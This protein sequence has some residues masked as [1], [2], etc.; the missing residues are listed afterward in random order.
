M[1][2]DLS[3]PE[4]KEFRLELL[5]LRMGVSEDDPTL[6]TIK[7]AAIRE[8]SIR[9]NLFAEL[10]REPATEGQRERFIFRL[11]MY[12]LVAKE[13]YLTMVGCN[14]TRAGKPLFKFKKGPEG[15]FL[16]MN[17]NQ[18]MAAWGLI[19]DETA[20]EIH[21]KVLELNPHWDI[22]S[23]TAEEVGLGE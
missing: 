11:P 13:V 7:Q 20:T 16:D 9:S 19:D 18:F 6:I 5:D 23:G 1:P 15:E 10:V 21:S 4:R 17:E 22:G 14:L 8:N 12:T 3:I 2:A